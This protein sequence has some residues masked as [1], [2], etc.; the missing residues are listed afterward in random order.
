[1]L[2]RVF[3]LVEGCPPALATD[4]LAVAVSGTAFTLDFAMP[5]DEKLLLVRS[6]D[7]AQAPIASAIAVHTNSADVGLM[8]S[9][10]MM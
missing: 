2:E 9:S 8:G 5:E 6:G 1:M 3:A 7:E 4:P 10:S